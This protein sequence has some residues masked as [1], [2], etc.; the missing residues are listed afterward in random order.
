MKARTLVTIFS[1]I[2]FTAGCSLFQ[3]DSIDGIWSLSFRGDI[4]YSFDMTI[5]PDMSF[6]KTMQVP[7][8]NG[9]IDVTFSG[10]VDEQ[11]NID[12]DIYA[13]GSKIG[14]LSGKLNYET[15][16]GEWYGSSYTG[17]WTALKKK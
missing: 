6:K 8:Q 12:S 3:K 4:T 13:F 5:N 17:K 9:D 2:I 15:G 10:K 14:K 7:S 11:G 16:E 1:V